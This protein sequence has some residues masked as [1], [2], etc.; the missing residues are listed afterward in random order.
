M[1]ELDPK[2][3]EAACE[4]VWN[5]IRPLGT[6]LW[7]ELD[8]GDKQLAIEFC[9]AGAALSHPPQESVPVSD[10]VIERAALKWAGNKERETFPED[11]A[12]F[13][14]HWGCF[15]GLKRYVLEEAALTKGD[16]E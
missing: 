16:A 6:Q 5:R 8:R 15:D 11:I 9:K 3:L 10:E 13:K 1:T 4:I 12:Y 2:G 7:H 14:F